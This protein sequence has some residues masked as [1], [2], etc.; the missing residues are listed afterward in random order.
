MSLEGLIV[1]L[2]TDLVGSTEL[3]GRLGED[4]AEQVRRAHFGAMRGAVQAHRGQEVKTLGDGLMTV[5]RSALDAVE[6]AAAMQGAVRSHDPLPADLEVAIRVGLHAGEPIRDEDD[7]FGTPVVLARRLCDAA[8]AGQI[9]ASD[10]VFGLAGSR[11]GRPFTPVGRLALKGFAEPVAAYEVDWGERPADG[12]APRPPAS[13]EASGSRRRPKR[14]S[15]PAA[16]PPATGAPEGPA[17]RARRVYGRAAELA[18]LGRLLDGAVQSGALALV[19][20]AGI[21]KT[22]LAEWAIERAGL[23]GRLVLKGNTHLGLP[24]PLGVF[25]DAVRGI[26]RMGLEPPPGD[27]LAASFPALVLAELGARAGDPTTQGATFEAAVRY[28][29][30]LADDSGLLI[31]L[32]DLHWADAS[33]FT[34]AA[35]LARTL[36]SDSIGMIVSYRPDEDV[37]AAALEEFRRELRRMRVPELLLGPLAPQEAGA[38][39]EELLGLR[40]EPAVEGE[41]I[42]LSGGNPFALEELAQA[43]VDSGWIDPATG[44]RQSEGSVDVPWTLAESIRARSSRLADPE[45]E[46]LQWAAVIGEQFDIRLLGAATG[47]DEPVVLEGLRACIAAG[48]VTEDRADYAGNRFAFRHAL[49]HEALAQERLVAER[50]RRHAAVLAAAERMAAEGIDVPPGELAR[51][52]VAAGDRRRIVLHSRAAARQA[53]DVGAIEEAVLHLERALQSW[54]EE[55]GKPARAELLL[56]CG[57][58]RL[59]LS[60]GDERAAE[61]LGGAREAALEFGDRGSAAVALSLLADARFEVGEREQALRDWEQSL[62]E[63]RSVGPAEAI[64]HALAGQARGLALQFDSAATAAADEGLALLPEAADADQARTRVSLLATRGMIDFFSYRVDEGRA[65]LIEAAR[66]AV[67]HQDDV[68][69]AR[70]HHILGDFIWTPPTEAA[71]HFARAAELVRRHGLQ[72]LEAWYVSLQADAMAR[73]GDW[74][75]TERLADEAERL[76]VEGERAAWTRLAVRIAQAER[77]LGLGQLD[78]SA[79]AMSRELAAAEANESPAHI[80][81]A[82]VSLAGLA[83]LRGESTELSAALRELIDAVPGGAEAVELVAFGRWLVLVELLV[84]NGAYADARVIGDALRRLYESPW[85]DYALAM[86]SAGDEPLEAVAR[87]IEDACVAL[88]AAGHRLEPGRMRVAASQVLAGLPGGRPAAAAL[89]RSAHAR[90]AELGSEAWCRRLEERLRE[91]DEPRR[92]RDGAAGG[93]TRRE[94]EVLNLLA[95]GLT[96]RQI[97]DRLVISEATAIRHVANIYT[98]LGAHRRTEAVHIATERGLIGNKSPAGDT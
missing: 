28:A 74:E 26:R 87:R 58:L 13:R 22:R 89:A 40:P 39:L 43:V 38:M 20:E 79:D 1:V 66:L 31:V 14:P 88:E 46:L 19:G 90:F 60:R 65:L 62:E 34:L 44:A 9:L 92:R 7:Y 80:A 33:S 96:N 98:K 21:G 49:I 72:G 29:Q 10:I 55:D 23:G 64:P 57:R 52:A 51:H 94:L 37:G 27:P 78:A 86:A 77:L 12:E 47:R 71:A 3:L 18:T 75:A 11:S 30:A 42:R 85:A 54:A 2:F 50:A 56:A 93:L 73:A 83:L 8:A 69:A 95:E 6:C 4:E 97:A 32:E 5:F 67:E 84:D 82:H 25:C 17:F 81:D 63:L 41:L 36:A 59:R 45:R 91:L 15:A 61:L 35:L 76:I 24:E 48:L 53:Y 68:G 16:Q 70:A